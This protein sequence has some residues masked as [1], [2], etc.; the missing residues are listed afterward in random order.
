MN[1]NTRYVNS[2]TGTLIG[3]S[4]HK[5]QFC[6][7]NKNCHHKT[8]A[9]HNKYLSQQTSFCHDKFYRDKHTFVTTNTSLSQQNTPFVMTQ[10][11]LSPQ[12][13]CLHKNMFVVTK[14]FCHDKHT[15]VATKMILAAAPANE[16]VNPLNS[17]STTTW[18]CFKTKKTLTVIHTAIGTGC[19][20]FIFSMPVM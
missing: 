2:T 8:C 10:V 19:F 3:G 1:I 6:H 14:Y 5:Y 12:H 18:L 15:F 9:C 16:K 13:F 17:S 11:C 7:N 4:C 20:L